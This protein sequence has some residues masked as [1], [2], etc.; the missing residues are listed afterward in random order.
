MVMAPGV[1]TDRGQPRV[2]SRIVATNDDRLE[3]ADLIDFLTEDPIGERR[4][5]AVMLVVR[6][7][8]T[9]LGCRR[10]GDN[11]LSG[12]ANAQAAIGSLRAAMAPL[13]QAEQAL[14]LRLGR[15][16]VLEA[17]DRDD[18]DRGVRQRARKLLTSRGGTG[19][20][21]SQADL[22]ERSDESLSPNTSDG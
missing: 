20:L 22:F 16:E 3:H 1:A 15:W 13:S 21:G 11:R 12:A 9:K 8:E 10:R 5:W 19:G 7:L 17:L 18:P 4:Y 6:M 14:M 2:R